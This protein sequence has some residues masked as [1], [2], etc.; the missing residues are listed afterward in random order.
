MDLQRMRFFRALT[1]IAVGRD[2]LARLVP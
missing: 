2:D 1:R